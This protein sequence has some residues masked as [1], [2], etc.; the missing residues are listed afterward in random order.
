MS[1]EDSK[2]AIGMV[3]Y[4]EMDRVR[5]VCEKVLLVMRNDKR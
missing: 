2:D 1:L 5:M 4:V 3:G